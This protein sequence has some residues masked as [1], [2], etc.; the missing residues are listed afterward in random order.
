MLAAGF[1]WFHLIPAIDRDELLASLDIQ[2]HTYV[3]AH[4][5]LACGLLVL[6][7]VLARMGL[8]RAKARPGIERYFADETLSIRNAA[9]LI[10]GG[11]RGFMRDVLEPADVRIFFPLVG[12]IFM[13]LLTCNFMGLVPGLLPPTDYINASFGIA[14]VVFLTFNFVGLKRDAVSY[15]K[16]LWGPV[17]PLGILLFPIE[18]I[19]L[20]FRPYSLT[21]RLT[22]NMFGD[23]TVFSIMSGLVPL[24]VPAVL[25][26][27]AILVSVVQAFVFSLLTTIYIG[28][29]LPHHD[30]D[31]AHH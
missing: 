12:G 19:S 27:L 14:V 10:M 26:T 29:S 24:V 22:G 25:L 9:E 3:H 8:E 13:Y 16:H 2:H 7:A 17:L 4:A 31:E 11:V 21:L 23:H 20:L 5:W 28:L 30:H 1:S 6:F 15:I 18:V